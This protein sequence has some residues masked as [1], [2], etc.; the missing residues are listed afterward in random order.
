MYRTWIALTALLSGCATPPEHRDVP[1]RAALGRVAVVA[2]DTA[3]EVNLRGVPSGKGKAALRGAAKWGGNCL[4]LLTSGS[5]SG[6]VCGAAVFVMAVVCPVAATI[7]ATKGALT[8][9]SGQGLAAARTQLESSAD[10]PQLQMRLREAVAAH[11]AEQFGE[12]YLPHGTREADTLIEARLTHVEVMATDP[13]A[14]APFVLAIAAQTRLIEAPTQS[15]LFESKSEFQSPARAL[16]SWTA[17]EAK[18]L[19]AELERGVAELGRR[20]VEQAFA[21]DLPGVSAPGSR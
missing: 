18:L 5:C 17:D 16:H 21:Q 14:G 9:A 13:S 3:P 6:S 2:V 20:I 1:P 4:Q 8:A 15:V 19:H 10:A 11:A 7:G 12:R